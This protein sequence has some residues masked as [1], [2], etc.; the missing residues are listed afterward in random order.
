MAL[1]LVPP[2]FQIQSWG[3]IIP[4]HEPGYVAVPLGMPGGKGS[5]SQ[6]LRPSQDPGCTLVTSRD[7]DLSIGPFAGSNDD[8]DD[9]IDQFIRGDDPP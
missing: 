2:P 5:F 8:D 7:A 1:I 3:P 4:P 6:A 9:D